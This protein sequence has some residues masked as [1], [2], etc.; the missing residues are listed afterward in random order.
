MPNPNQ[1]ESQYSAYK[2]RFKAANS[3]AFGFLMIFMDNELHAPESILA[4]VSHYQSMYEI[5]PRQPWSAIEE[6]LNELKVK[7]E[8]AAS[9]A[10]DAQTSIENLIGGMRPDEVAAISNSAVKGKMD[11][12]FSVTLAKP[13]N[14]KN[15]TFDSTI[16]H[17]TGEQL[18]AVKQEREK[19]S[20]EKAAADAPE[21]APTGDNLFNVE[22]GAVVLNVN[23]V[24]SP[25]SGIPIFELKT[26]DRIMVKID[27][28]SKRG[29]YFIDLLGARR[30]NDI[31]PV[32]ATVNDMRIGKTN[33]HIVLVKIGEGVYG[34]VSEAEKVK[35]KRVDP[36]TDSKAAA[37]MQQAIQAA[38]LKKQ[39]AAGSAAGG[40]EERSGSRLQWLL[41]IGGFI[42]FAMLL[43]IIT[44]I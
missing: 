10:R 9:M 18:L 37:N 44:S 21:A 27:P 1:P 16:E 12:L 34:R 17:I 29:S 40:Q 4:L 28:A 8:F 24:L 22:E 2:A 32:P 3:N 43:L 36:G 31:L 19:R 39:A 11:H 33:E 23:F 15:V 38:G 6:R 26:G 20:Q 30:D 41:Y 35:I 7:G 13:L 14:D 42:I 25:V 5:D